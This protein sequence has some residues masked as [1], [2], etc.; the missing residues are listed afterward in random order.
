M[1]SRIGPKLADSSGSE[2][3]GA[4]PRLQLAVVAEDRDQRP[5]RRR[6]HRRSRVEEGE[7]DARRREDAADTV[8]ERHRDQPTP[9]AKPQRPAPDSLEIDL[10]AGEEE[11]HAEAEVGE[12]V[13]EVIG[14][15]DVED[16]GADENAQEQLDDDD[17][18]RE[19]A[20][21]QRHRDGR[22]GRDHDDDEKRLCVDVDHLG[23]DPKPGE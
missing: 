17:G 13:N 21:H 11:E 2:Q 7:D 12:E 5:D 15:G 14:L 23:A 6:R 3:V 10:V 1:T 9:G 19:A 4:E 18:R 16:L 20:R 8:G 22:E